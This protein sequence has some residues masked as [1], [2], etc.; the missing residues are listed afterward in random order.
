[1]YQCT[2]SVQLWMW[3]TIPYLQFCS[4]F[5]LYL[6]K[7]GRKLIMS[8]RVGRSDCSFQ[9]GWLSCQVFFFPAWAFFC[10]KIRSRKGDHG[11]ERYVFERSGGVYVESCNSSPDSSPRIRSHHFPCSSSR[12]RTA[13]ATTNTTTLSFSF[14]FRDLKF[15]MVLCS[16]PGSRGEDRIPSSVDACSE[17]LFQQCASAWRWRNLVRLQRP[18]S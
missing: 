3:T 7:T 14:L 10:K 16:I 8:N 17:A 15:W 9:I 11:R 1:M 18:P 13:T 6:Q 12:F 5:Y 4:L 2:T